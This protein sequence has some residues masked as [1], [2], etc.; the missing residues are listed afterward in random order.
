MDAIRILEDCSTASRGFVRGEV[1]EIGAGMSAEDA[2]I[3]VRIGRAVY[4][5]RPV[6]QA[7]EDK[8][9]RRKEQ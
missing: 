2:D 7:G 8:P 3:L 4:C 9:R 6:P 5:S 1:V